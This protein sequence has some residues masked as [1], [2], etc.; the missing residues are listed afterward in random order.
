MY[1]RL[2]GCPCS[3]AGERAI[4]RLWGQLVTRG[5]MRVW[6]FLWA[7]FAAISWGAA[8]VLGKL[9]LEGLDPLS[10]ISARTLTAAGLV[11]VWLA[12]A[13]RRRRLEKLR[14]RTWFFIAL[15]G[16]C[17]VFVGDL[18]YYSALKLGQPGRVALILAGAP[19]VTLTLSAWLFAERVG[20]LKLLGG[21]LVAV[22]V[23]LVGWR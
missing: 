11:W 19:L 16:I 20:P 15:E 4:D 6:P 12:A 8:P 18:A 23:A 5:G 22:G 14:L 3:I 21:V 2:A 7:A 1:R 9:G 10:A 17:T 13:G